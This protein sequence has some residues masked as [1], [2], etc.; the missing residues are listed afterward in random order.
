[1]AAGISEPPLP[2]GS[3]VP[4]WF[5]GGLLAL[6][7]GLRFFP[8]RERAAPGAMATD[9]LLLAAGLAYAV[10]L[11]L[12][13]KTPWLLMAPDAILLLFALP[14]GLGLLVTPARRWLQVGFVALVA[15][16][17]HPG[18]HYYVE[19]HR[20]VPALAGALLA[21]PGSRPSLVLVQGEHVWPF[22]FYL[23]ELR[24]AYGSVPDAAQAEVWLLQASGSEAPAAPGRRAVPFA[25][26][27]NELWWAL[28]PEPLAGRMEEALRP[29]R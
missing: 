26:R 14:N 12:P 29:R 21:D 15:G 23:R 18:R 17:A 9:F 10:H 5:T 20:D 13:Y 28:A 4:W 16:L 27:D 1:V 3:T 22:P 2:M 19:T 6:A 25:V 24:V 7:A 11:T 8:R